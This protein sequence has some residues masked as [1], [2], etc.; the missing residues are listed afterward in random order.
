M[1]KITD[2]KGT[3][4]LNNGVLMPYF[5]LGVF[6]AARG[7]ETIQAIHWAFDAGYRHIDTASVYMN[8][9][10]VGEAVR[11]SSI[12]RTDVFITTKV[13]NSEQG[14]QHTLNAFQRSLDKLKMDYI[15][16]YLIH[17][18]VGDSYVHT[19]EALEE[20][21]ARKLVRA[22]GV[23]NFLEP[24]LT[25]LLNLKGTVPMVNQNEFHP[26]L[27]QQDL[28]DF[29]RQNN[30]VYEAWSPI[31]KGRVNEFPE[32][33]EIANKYGKTPVQ[34]VLRWDL[35]KEVVTIPK[36]VQRERI[37]SN[38]DL[39]DFELTGDEIRK[40][41]TMDQNYRIGPDPNNVNF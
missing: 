7:E 29:C 17:W 33:I 23:S 4:R 24:H 27:V 5:G 40:I 11:T 21:Y 1:Q 12:K 37:I 28:L 31:M 3:F 18:P 34:V 15:D 16:L 39:F 26:R 41:D 35:Q 30:I 10:S 25:S 20:L 8:E 19:W 14:Y 32:I 2:I 36:S 13:W 9:A 38:A 6:Q 22:I